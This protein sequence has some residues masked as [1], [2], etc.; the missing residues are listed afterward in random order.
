MLRSLM[1]LSGTGLL[2]LIAVGGPLPAADWPQWGG[3]GDKNMVSDA[4]GLPASFDP[5]RSRGGGFQTDMSTTRNVKWTARLGSQTYGNPVVSGG[6]VF[7]GT[8]DASVRDERLRR[9]KGGVM[10]CFDEATGKRLW[11]LVIPKFRTDKKAFNYD[12]LNLGVC[13]SATVEGGRAYVLSSRGEVVC[14]DVK[15]QAD[16][17]GGPFQDEGRYMVDE[18]RKP[19]ELTQTDPDI[20]WC[21]DMVHDLPVWPQDA[22][23]GAVLIHGGLVYAPTSNGVDSSHRNVPYPDAPSLI[24]LDKQ[25]G[26]LVAKDDERVGRRLYHGQWSSPTLAEVGGRAQIVY[27]AGDGVVY[28]FE[29]ADPRPKDGKVALLRKI[30]WC[31]CNPHDYRFE[32]GKPVP[33]KKRRREPG[34]KTQGVGPSEIIATPVFYRNRIYVAVGQDPRH[35]EG[36]G[37]LSCIDATRTGDVTET[38]VI[39]QSKLVDRSLSTVSIADGLLYVAD[40]SGRIHCFDAE[41]GKRYWVHQT[42]SPLWS[43]TFVADGKVYLGTE[44]RELWVL[45]AGKDKKVLAKTRLPDK[46]SNTPIVA[47]GVLYVATGNCL[48]AVHETPAAGK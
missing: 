27:G 5:G 26:R 18:G 12:H 7:V 1:A 16:G 33:Y 8:N 32:K 23:S 15:G 40:Y 37:A 42:H 14:L 31:N 30:W 47:N 46:M 13:A 20:L 45:K 48:Y 25:T 4:R 17:N 2:A 6:R 41:T 38:G 28:A 44:K 19:A 10:L 34:G 29:P 43:S 35:K 21:F 11:Q 9:T 22:S 3:R 39:W 36:V 24:A